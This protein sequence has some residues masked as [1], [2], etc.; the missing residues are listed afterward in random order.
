MKVVSAYRTFCFFTKKIFLKLFVIKIPANPNQNDYIFTVFPHFENFFLWK[1][2]SRVFLPC[3]KS[4]CTRAT[5][6][7]FTQAIK[8]KTNYAMK[9][10]FLSHSYF[11]R[12]TR[13]KAGSHKGNKGKSFES[14]MSYFVR[15]GIFSVFF[16]SHIRQTKDCWQ[17]THEKIKICLCLNNILCYVLS[18]TTMCATWDEGSGSSIVPSCNIDINLNFRI[19]ATLIECN[20]MN[21]FPQSSS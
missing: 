18:F 12:I 3:M 4:S 19:K 14:I 7:I 17:K 2:F 9:V 10:S 8:H 20:L 1:C 21:M 15:W 13:Q 11:Y 6:Q 5:R 16:L